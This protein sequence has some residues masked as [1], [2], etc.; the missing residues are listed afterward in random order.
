MELHCKQIWLLVLVLLLAT[1]A[2]A[3]DEEQQALRRL[4]RAPLDIFHVS[5]DKHN[6]VPSIRTRGL[7]YEKST[8]SEKKSKYEKKAKETKSEKSDNGM[9]YVR[10]VVIGDFMS[11]SMSMSMS[12]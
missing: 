10:Q 12:M 7:K 2:N 5:D 11:M 4:R 1:T 3:F 9:K 8:K 6:E